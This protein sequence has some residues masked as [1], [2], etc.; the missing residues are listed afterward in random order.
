M[1]EN[2]T[3]DEGM[4]R[5]IL[6]TLMTF[7]L[8]FLLSVSIGH[9]EITATTKDGKVVLLKDDGTWYYAG[10]KPEGIYEVSY[11]KTYFY[12]E[13]GYEK[14]VKVKFRSTEE[15]KSKVPEDK[16]SSLSRLALHVCQLKLRNQVSFVPLDVFLW[17][18]EESGTLYSVNM[19][20]KN[21]YGAESKT[22][23]YCKVPPDY[24]IE[25]DSCI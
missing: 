24:K 23:C 7:C 18:S 14:R 16:L 9:A 20:G 4:L 17:H 22:S 25:L 2:A 15:G 8:F 5:H 6:L 12:A 21:A 10:Q 13:D 1:L 11:N 19:L 3:G